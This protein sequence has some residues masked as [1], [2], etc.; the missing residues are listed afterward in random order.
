MRCTNRHIANT[1]NDIVHGG[2]RNV[3]SE[4]KQTGIRLAS[5]L[6]QAYVCTP[7]PYAD[8]THTHTHTHSCTGDW[9]AWQ[10][11]TC[12]VDRL[13]RRRGGPLRQKLK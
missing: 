2:S 9:A 4:R 1:D 12:Q 7:M 6:T 10:P 13:V 5:A 3:A 11:G 8:H